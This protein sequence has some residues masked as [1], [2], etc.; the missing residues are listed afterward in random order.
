MLLSKKL[1]V[2]F[3]I[4]LTFNFF[5][6]S[7]KKTTANKEFVIEAN[8]KMREEQRSNILYI[9]D[10]EEIL[11][12]TLRK[13]N[14]DDI[15]SIDVIKNAEGIKKYTQKKYDGVVVIYLKKDLK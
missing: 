13:I 4:L 15:K 6:C 1:T 11:Q 7:S 3:L 10:G 14:P 2:L 9:L 12:D 5:N 8:K